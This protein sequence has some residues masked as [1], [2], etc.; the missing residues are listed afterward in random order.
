MQIHRH[1]H[2]IHCNLEVFRE[3]IT[4]MNSVC[5]QMYFWELWAMVHAFTLHFLKFTCDV[6]A[7]A[8]SVGHAL[9][10][11][12]S[13]CL[14]K[15][16]QNSYIYFEHKGCMSIVLRETFHTYIFFAEKRNSYVTLPVHLVQ[17]S[18]VTYIPLC[19]KPTLL[20]YLILKRI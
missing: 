13:H 4:V 12:S 19:L 18:E 15:K 9:F 6:K 17:I 2:W 8:A 10:C 7:E 20:V 11:E 16:K 1:K 5:W 3:V 14:M